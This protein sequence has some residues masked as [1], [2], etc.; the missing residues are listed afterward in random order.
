MQSQLLK[1]SLNYQR[2]G[3][4]NLPGHISY[5]ATCSNLLGRLPNEGKRSAL[6]NRNHFGGHEISLEFAS[7]R[8]VILREGGGG[9][10][11]QFC[12]E[13]QKLI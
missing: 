11:N 5:I 10:K 13:S 1:P 9:G 2:D 12:A 7:K 3:T 6:G 4:L 8:P